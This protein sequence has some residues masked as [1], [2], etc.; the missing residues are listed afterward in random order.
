MQTYAEESGKE[1]DNYK[2]I[3]SDCEQHIRELSQ[4][5]QRGSS[6][7]NEIERLSQLLREREAQINELNVRL[8]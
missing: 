4:Q 8:R 2:R 6:Y 7:A 3:V 1:I 5:A